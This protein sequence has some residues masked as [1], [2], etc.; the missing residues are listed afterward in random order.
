MTS[1][2][3]VEDALRVAFFPDSYHEVDG[4]ANT[5]RQFEAFAR[6]RGLPFLVVHGVEEGGGCASTEDRRALPR[7]KVCFALDKKHDFDVLFL[8]YLRQVEA[9][10]REF[11]PDIVHVTGPSDV[12]LLGTLAAHNLRIPLA[13]SWH[14]NLHQY[15]QQ[16]SAGFLSLF[17]RRV[18]EPLGD[19][20][21]E[22]SLMVTLRFYHIA[23][24]LYAPNQELIQ[25]VEKGIRKPCFLMERGVDTWLFDPSRRDRTDNQFTIGFVGR[26]SVEKNVRM[27]VDL[28][29]ALIRN[30]L[31][32]FRFL[33]VGRGGEEPYLRANLQN[34][35]FTGVLTGDALGRAY[36]NM[37]VFVFPSKTDTY[38]NVVL[39]ALSSGVPAVVSDQG[40]PRF[41]VRPGETGFVASSPVDF[42]NRVLT[43]ARNPG[44]LA[45]MRVAARHHAL[46]T[47]WD[48]VF[49]YVYAGY[50]RGLRSGIPADK[51]VR[52]RRRRTVLTGAV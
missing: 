21:R 4:V 38:G 7:G 29:Q 37:D 28:E 26:L 18:A 27:L 39:E 15:A 41:I 48:K 31:T 34:A 42:A 1:T 51:R 33:I 47:S 50:E 23:Q 36:A 25:L 12:G 40:G 9:W 24:I 5:S 11:N 46:S 22:F 14:T 16:R 44:Q 30:G 19:A 2:V 45:M 52:S 49:E 10:L 3:L 43:L 20:I 35:E 17:P 13:A 6:R 8:R 32:N